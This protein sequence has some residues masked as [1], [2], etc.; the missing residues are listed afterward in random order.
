MLREIVEK[1]QTR[2]MGRIV[3]LDRARTFDLAL[4][5][6]DSF[7]MAFVFL[8]SGRFVHNAACG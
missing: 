3:A 1:D 8:V 2:A 6:S 4:L 7:F 5:F